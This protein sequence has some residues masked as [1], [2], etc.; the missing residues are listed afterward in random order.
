M[1]EFGIPFQE[2]LLRGLRP[3]PNPRSGQEALIECFNLMP[4]DLGLLGHVEL[5]PI[6]VAAPFIQ[7]LAIKGQDEL[8]W[9]I[10]G[11]AGLDTV[12]YS[13][14]PDATAFGF[15]TV[16]VTPVTVPY[17]LQVDAVDSPATQLYIW[18]ANTSGDLTVFTAPPALGTGYDVG[19]GLSLRALS[20]AVHRLAALTAL[21]VYWSLVGS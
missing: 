15:V 4:S 9:Y 16:S 2:G 5:L 13:T 11:G 7:Y 21:D 3:F 20:G 6:G 12:M 19:A 8:L 14:V 1:R 10:V 18:P 17:W